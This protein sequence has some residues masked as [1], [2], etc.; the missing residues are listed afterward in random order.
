M[1]ICP[2]CKSEASEV[3]SPEDTLTVCH[4]CEVI[5]EGQAIEVDEDELNHLAEQQHQEWQA[6]IDQDYEWIA[7][8]F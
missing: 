3:G 4:E 2:Y 5:I 6:A 1:K 7:E 8:H